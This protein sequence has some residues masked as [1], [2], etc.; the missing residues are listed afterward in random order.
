MIEEAEKEEKI[1]PDQKTIVKNTSGNT[2]KTMVDI[3]K[4]CAVANGICALSSCQG[5]LTLFR[6]VSK[7]YS[8]CSVSVVIVK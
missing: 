2:K 8:K 5:S 3:T 6:L 4:W 7:E 1:S